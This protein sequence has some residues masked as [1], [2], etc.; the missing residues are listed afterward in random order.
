MHEQSCNLN[1]EIS[2]L[3]QRRVQP[4]GWTFQSPL[5]K[6]L[7]SPLSVDNQKCE[8]ISN[9]SS[10]LYMEESSDVEWWP[11]RYVMASM[12]TGRLCEMHNS[13]AAFVA[14][15]TANR[16]FPSTLIDAIP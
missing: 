14:T 1:R 4:V 16:S 10:H 11:T 9:G 3:M 6:M 7:T 13:R 2:F 15:Y 8:I 5:E 12:S